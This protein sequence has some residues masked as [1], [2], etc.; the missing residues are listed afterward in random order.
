MLVE[1]GLSAETPRPRD[2]RGRRLAI[3]ALL[4]ALG[5]L[6]LGYGA[7]YVLAGDRVPR[8]TTVEGVA[9]GGL[10]PAA[11]ESRLRAALEPRS[12]K[13]IAVSVDGNRRTVSPADAGLT[14]DYA[15]SVAAAGGGRSLHPGRLWDHYVS[16][17]DVEA[18]LEV[19]EAAMDALLASLAKDVESPVVEGAV[20]FQDGVATPVRA[21]AGQVLDPGPA[22]RA[23][24]EQF[25]HDGSTTL[26]RSA[27]EPVIDD[28]EVDRAMREFAVPAMSAP[29][30][31]TLGGE[32]VVAPPE[33]FGQALSMV[34]QGGELSPVVDARKLTTVLKPVMTT[35]GKQPVDA[36]F[37]VVDGKPRV[38]PA[39]SGVKFDLADL[40]QKFAA[41]LVKP[42]GER[43]AEVKA[44]LAK[45]DFTT[46]EAR[47]LGIEEQVSTFTTYF[48][49]AEYRNV[50]LSRAASL[51]NGTL[52][53]PGETFSLNETVGERTEENGFTEG[54]VIKDGL[55]R[56]E[57][58]GGVSQI[59][60]TTFNA[61]FFA[62][63]EDVQHKPH[64]VYISRY[65]E[66][67][68]A[69]VAWPSVDLRFRNTTPHGVFI[70]ARVQKAPSGGQGSAT[71]SMYSTKYW[72][73]SSSKGARHAFTEPPTRYLDA[74]DCEASDGGP[75]F[76]VD[77]TRTFRRA[78][79]RTVE[80]VE[81]FHT[82]Y[83]P[84][85]RLICGKKPPAQDSP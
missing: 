77:V 83:N 69:T 32:Q 5:L 2:G 56:T 42:A 43:T 74:P 19:D 25:L 20:T 61:M 30:T 82:V 9:I 13:P 73:I 3:R 14:V 33:L 84:E 41:V 55:F 24:E 59:A 66:G 70:T 68:E 85:P 71:V 1:D 35:L 76:T 49:Y 62:G 80:R 7:L 22:R 12:R 44:S 39:K 18:V 53:K 65:P 60:T 57:L 21:R 26:P 4:G 78:G 81:E 27:A 36:T 11:A 51:I 58:G 67:R 10:R 8:G 63:L 45:P 28:A 17:P 52:L 6:V 40:E 79:S 31:L 29:V 72:D 16:A 38:V 15:A 75:G 47:A 50:N 34:P 64:S 23:I 37:R 54:Y 46:E 48:P